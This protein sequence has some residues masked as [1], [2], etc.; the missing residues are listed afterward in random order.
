M[1][2]KGNY[3]KLKIG[4][5]IFIPFAVF[6]FYIS[7]DEGNLIILVGSL[8]CF[9]MSFFLIHSIF[10][11]IYFDDY[12]LLLKRY[13]GPPL[14]INYEDVNHVG[15]YY[16]IV[17]NKKLRIMNMENSQEFEAILWEHLVKINGLFDPDTR[18]SMLNEEYRV[19]Q[20]SFS[21]VSIAVI[22]ALILSIII[23]D[24]LKIEE[25]SRIQFGIYVMLIMSLIYPI[26]KWRFRNRIYFKMSD[27]NEG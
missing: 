14:V 6:L 24:W 8:F 17:K 10:Q 9:G 18:C 7:F 20:A 2:F 19:Q 22:P 11:V 1:V 23:P 15:L 4:A 16:I 21:S 25:G 13:L 5:G 27:K 12:R 3:L 26:Q